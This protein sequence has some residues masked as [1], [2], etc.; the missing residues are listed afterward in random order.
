MPPPPSHQAHSMSPADVAAVEALTGTTLADAIETAVREESLAEEIEL[1]NA[2]EDAAAASDAAQ[3]CRAK[4]S[5]PTEPPAEPR[6]TREGAG[7]IELY[8]QS[9]HTTWSD[10]DQARLSAGSH[11]QVRD[12]TYDELCAQCDAAVAALEALSAAAKRD[13][14]ALVEVY[15]NIKSTLSG[16]N[17]SEDMARVA[18]ITVQ[19]A[20]CEI[21][22]PQQLEGGAN[23]T[24]SGTADYQG[25]AGTL[26][27]SDGLLRWVPAQ[28]HKSDSFRRFIGRSRHHDA[29][30]DRQLEFSNHFC[31]CVKCCTYD[32]V[33][34]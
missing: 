30:R 2:R 13:R 31:G 6:S 27:V 28:G 17:L 33:T 14:A 22:S 15:A 34:A 10:Y 18:A 24:W 5:A 7:K 11:V 26:S 1:I 19:S 4:Q 32:L 20:L 25:K 29:A 3:R 8:S 9:E 23:S 16:G 21:L 12:I